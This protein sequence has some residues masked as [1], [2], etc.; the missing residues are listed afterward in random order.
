MLE[1]NKISVI[2]SAAGSG[3]RMGPNGKLHLMIRGESVLMRTMRKFSVLSWVDEMIVVV[4][5]TELQQVK[6]E[7]GAMVLPFPLRFVP[8]GKE[9]H[10]SIFAG[11]QAT[12]DDTDIILTHDGARPFVRPKDILK[13]AKC[14]IEKGACAL[15]VPLV[16]TV[17]VVRD[18]LH[19]LTTPDRSTLYRVQTPQGFHKPLIMAAYEAAFRENWTVT[20]DCSMVE[21]F[22]KPVQLVLGHDTNIKITTQKDLWF[23]ERI[24]EEEEREDDISH[25]DRV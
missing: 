12:A 7:I 22:G 25:G 5:E 3:K 21:I 11:L 20:D 17:K 14:A 10:D 6:E 24:A 2:I 9:R 1:G 8:G 18:D 4:K 15:A 23:G 19:V 16:D 13:L